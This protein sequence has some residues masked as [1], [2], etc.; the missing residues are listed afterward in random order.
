MRHYLG[1]QESGQGDE[2]GAGGGHQERLQL[3]VGPDTA[4]VVGEGDDTGKHALKSCTLPSRTAT[5]EVF[6]EF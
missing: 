2:G 5:S 1:P 3:R 4:W 6:K